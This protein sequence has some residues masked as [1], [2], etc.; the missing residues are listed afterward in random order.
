MMGKF[1]MMDSKESWLRQLAAEKYKK[2]SELT[3]VESTKI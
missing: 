3:K 2:F 1:K